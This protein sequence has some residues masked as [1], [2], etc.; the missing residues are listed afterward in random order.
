MGKNERAGRTLLAMAKV[1]ISL[2]ILYLLLRACNLKLSDSIENLLSVNKLLLV[3]AVLQFPFLVFLKSWRW[4]FLIR[5]AG[6]KYNLLSCFRSYLAG[7]AV[8]VITPGRLGELAKACYLKAEVGADLSSSFRTV[9]GDRMYDLVFL[10]CFG[11]VS[12]LNI[13]HEFS[14]IAIIMQLVAVCVGAALIFAGLLKAGRGINISNER[15]RRL[16][17]LVE[18][19]VNDL[20]ERR[21]I[22]NWLLTVFAY[23]IYFAMCQT[24]LVAL[25]IDIPFTKV[26]FIIS[27]MSLILLIPVSI[28][29]FGPREAVLIFLLG[30][31]GVT[32]ET[33]LSFSLLQFIVFFL[34]GG[35]LGLAAMLSAPLPLWKIK[36]E[37]L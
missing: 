2:L 4:C 26:C 11:I 30:R 25:D 19:V 29:G 10:V 9:I 3:F 28:A 33:A 14:L 15:L 17:K 5:T 36:E 27:T 8:G 23:L 1:L 35:L 12:Y 13:F 21:S 24:L 20:G 7:F 16:F 18:S 32:A 31:Y 37:S 22:R 6:F 34:F